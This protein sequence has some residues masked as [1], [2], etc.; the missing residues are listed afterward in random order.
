MTIELL[1]RRIWARSGKGDTQ[2]KKA[3][4]ASSSLSPLSFALPF[5][6]QCLVS[7]N[8]TPTPTHTHTHTHTPCAPRNRHSSHR[9]LF[10]FTH[11][12]TDTS[13]F[14]ACLSLSL[15][16]RARSVGFLLPLW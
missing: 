15:F 2:E 7:Q 10:T 11:T 1:N 16:S 12:H 8:T 9:L 4:R 3:K 6:S 14:F 13:F 5:Y